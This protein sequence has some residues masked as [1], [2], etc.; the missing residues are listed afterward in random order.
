MSALDGKVLLF[1]GPDGSGRFTL[2]KAIG[3]TL[4]IPM[5]ISYTTRPKRPNETEGTDYHFVSEEQFKKMQENGEF[6]EAVQADGFYYG[7]RQEDCQKLLD[8][9]GSFFAVLSPEGC[10]I[11]KK[12]FKETLTIFIYADRE[13]VTQRQIERGDDPATIERHLKHYD[14]IMKYKDKCDIS[15]P[16]YDLASTAQELTRRIE[17]FLGITHHPDSKY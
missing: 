7:I 1:V 10:E 14:E 15:I 17:E 13:T 2:A 16:N 12:I 11:F 8:Q 3:V 6:I 9:A 4:Q 5:V